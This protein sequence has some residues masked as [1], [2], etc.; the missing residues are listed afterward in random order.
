MM[1]AIILL[2]DYFIL[3]IIFDWLNAWRTELT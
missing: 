2:S 1:S 3:A